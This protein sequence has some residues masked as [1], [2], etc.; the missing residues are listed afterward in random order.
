M[1]PF[2]SW[3]DSRGTHSGQLPL[4]K[5]GYMKKKVLCTIMSM[6]V[7]AGLLAGCDSSSGESA[8]A[9]TSSAGEAEAADTTSSEET[10]SADAGTADL[11][12]EKLEVAT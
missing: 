5:E 8:A 4:L 1:R 2:A 3:I 12:G 11:S 7:L 6:S 10:A 9:D